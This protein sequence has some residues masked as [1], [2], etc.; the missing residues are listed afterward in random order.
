MRS[1]HLCTLACTTRIQI[2][3][4]NRWIYSW[5]HT[6]YSAVHSEHDVIMWSALLT[7]FRIRLFPWFIQSSFWVGY[8]SHCYIIS[9]LIVILPCLGLFKWHRTARPHLS[10]LIIVKKYLAWIWW[11][12]GLPRRLPKWN[13]R[14]LTPSVE[15]CCVV[16]KS[17]GLSPS[18]P[19]MQWSRTKYEDAV[20]R[21]AIATG[22]VM[23]GWCVV[24]SRALSLCFS[25]R[26]L[27]LSEGRQLQ[28]I[29]VQMIMTIC[30]EVLHGIS[31]SDRCGMFA[32]SH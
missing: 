18:S 22:R 26:S 32:M 16:D 7:L 9:K 19:G 13:S 29:G 30:Y 20:D 4:C 8:S 21:A 3:K 23:R 28:L 5:W 25:C 14:P 1:R 17:S 15:T 27:S 6:P 2:A 12:N 31:V 10:C 24:C 11:P